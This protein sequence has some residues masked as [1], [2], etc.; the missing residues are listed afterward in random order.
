MKKLQSAIICQI[1]ICSLFFF[2]SGTGRAYGYDAAKEFEKAPVT[3]PAPDSNKSE[4]YL[5]LNSM[6]PF[7]VGEVKG[8]VVVIEFMSALCEFCSLNAKV[9]NNVYRTVQENPQVASQ[10]KFLAV[11]LT[12]TDAELN[13]FKQ[14]HGVLFPMLNDATAAIG[15]AMG[16]IPTPTTIIVSTQ[17]GKVLY[18]HVGL[19]WSSDGFVKKIVNSLNKN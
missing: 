8:K 4:A 15:S 10:V 19:I 7:K 11:G 17:T 2:M 5:G 18:S 16:D 3:L 13:A 9:M 14:Q 1:V 6:K 12:S